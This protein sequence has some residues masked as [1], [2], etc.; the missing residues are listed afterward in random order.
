MLFQ[1]AY[2]IDLGTGTVRIYDGKKDAVTAEKNMIAVRNADTVFAVGDEAWEIFERTPENI[3]V[4]T[5]M[6]NGRISDVLLEE[7]ILQTLL[8]RN[9]SSLGYRPVIYLSVPADMTEIEKRA[10]YSVARR[11]KLRKCRVYLVEKPVADALALGIPIHRTKGSMIIHI[12][13]QST[14]LSV[15]ADERVIIS[16]MI[17]CGG[18]HFDEAIRAS[19]RRKNSF[20]ISVRTAG[21]LKTALADLEEGRKEGRKV[22]GVDTLTGLPRDGFI[23]ARTVT[24]A[25]R[26]QLDRLTEE[27]RRFLDR[28]PPQ[29]RESIRQEGIYLTGGSTCLPGLDRYMSRRL[30]YSML[31]SRYYD[32]CT[33]CGLRELISHPALQRWAFVPRMRKY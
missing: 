29:V 23:T 4:I 21:E 27:I 28:I 15:F 12:G 33:I 5:P 30:E 22:M 32:Q 9:R 14:E 24:E 1:Y 17:P 26:E 31:L 2:G 3:Q 10:Y 13:D 19:V 16:R 7:Y 6:A 20:Q 25:V 8:L 11:G 18:R